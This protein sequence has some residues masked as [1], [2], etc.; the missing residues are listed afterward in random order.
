MKKKVWSGLVI[1]VIVV[2]AIGYVTYDYFVGNHVQIRSVL[3]Q[4]QEEGTAMLSADWSETFPSE[5]RI[6]PESSVFFSVTTSKE[7]VNIEASDVT[8][9]WTLP[10]GEGA[11]SQASAVVKLDTIDSGNGK[12]DGHIKES[13]YLDVAQFPE[14]SFTMT[15]L[16]EWPEDLPHNE[17]FE[18]TVTGDLTIKGVT[19]ETVFQMKGIAEESSIRLD[20]SA[21]IFFE[22]YNVKKPDSVISSLDEE[23]ALSLQLILVPAMQDTSSEEAK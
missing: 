10:D 17:L 21:T 19:K 4:S 8:G 2:G 13:E 20:G 14:A 15:G 5:W 18:F 9:T 22:D 6:D 1:G 16:A 7:K 3:G 12:R 11:N 23:I